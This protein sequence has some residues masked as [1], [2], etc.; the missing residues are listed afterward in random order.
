M[1]GKV[2]AAVTPMENDDSRNEARA[3]AKTAARSAQWLALVLQHHEHIEAAFAAV[4]AAT[5]SA[6]CMEAQKALANVLMGHSIAEEAVLYPAL[7]LL[8]E[9]SDAETAYAQQADAKIEMAVLDKLTPLTKEHA[10]KLE[11]IRAAVAHHVYEEEG[12]WFL[13]LAQKASADAQAK[14]AKQYRE[15][16]D[17]YFAGSKRA[18]TDGVHASAAA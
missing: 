14:I 15:E 3:K 10:A 1:L 2:M 16:F 6:A 12:T 17:K 18:A 7:A 4:K 11:S 9:K 13:D 8:D 5:T